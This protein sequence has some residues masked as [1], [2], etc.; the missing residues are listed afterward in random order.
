MRKY[1]L[2]FFFISQ[3]LFLIFMIIY[4]QKVSLGDAMHWSWGS[5]STFTCNLWL[6]KNRWKMNWLL[7][8][9]NKPT[10]LTK[11]LEFFP[12]SSKKKKKIPNIFGKLWRELKGVEFPRFW[13]FTFS[14]ILKLI[15]LNDNFITQWIGNYQIW[16]VT[17]DEEVG[18]WHAR[19]WLLEFK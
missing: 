18:N 14:K 4:K 6:S 3:M 9:T 1:I 13:N 16:S 15:A 11:S 17:A 10:A 7:W 19:K 12:S 5:I 8:N 2:I